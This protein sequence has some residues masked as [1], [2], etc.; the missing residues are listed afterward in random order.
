MVYAPEKHYVLVQDEDEERRLSD[1][2]TARWWWNLQ[3]RI[4][5]VSYFI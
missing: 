1:M 4:A 2:H 3:V 5:S